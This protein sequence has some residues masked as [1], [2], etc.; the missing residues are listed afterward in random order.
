MKRTSAAVCGPHVE[1]DATLI[2]GVRV[3]VGDQFLDL[4]VRGKLETIALALKN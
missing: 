2:G 3:A 4:S 1:V